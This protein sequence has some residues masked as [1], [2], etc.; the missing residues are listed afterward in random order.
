MIKTIFQK[1]VDIMEGLQGD[2]QPFAVV[3]GY[4]EAKPSLFP[5]ALMDVDAGM[6]QEDLASHVK[7]LTVNVIV[8]ILIRQKNAEAATL[9][10]LELMDSVI[11]RFTESDVFDDLDGT[12]D[13]MDITAMEPIFFTGDQPLFGF[14]MVISAK[15]IM[16]VQ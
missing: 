14:D 11:S 12:A 1:V 9:Q 13:I 6:R 15:K 5:C 16:S 7:W 2:G 10:R 4:P 3:Y 8:R